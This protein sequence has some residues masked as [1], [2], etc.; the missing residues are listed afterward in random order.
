MNAS[1]QKI[2]LLTG[3][4]RGLGRAL[5]D[6][7]TR[8]GHIVA[9]CARSQDA[10][11]A[12]RDAHPPPHHFRAVDVAGEP[13]VAAWVEEVLRD[14]GTPDLVINN[15]A[16]IN[17]PAPLWEVPPE[18]F[19]AMMDVNLKGVAWVIR[20]AVP[21]MIEAGRGVIANLSSGWGRST[22]P[23]VAPYCA[24]KW[25][26]EGL[27]SALARELPAGLAAVAVNPGII[28]TDMVDLVFGPDAESFDSPETWGET[29]GPFFLRLGPR[30]N[31]KS[32][33][34]PG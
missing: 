27:T 21:A 16:L 17:E 30:D 10:I 9:A 11:D 18:Q 13:A 8:R 25:G 24:S 26:I 29:A 34:I 31:G 1:T 5:V 7:F 20:H 14:V 15:A 6:Y 2:I 19:S 22:S 12:L 32:L 3:A 23:H 4:S 28:R 33:S